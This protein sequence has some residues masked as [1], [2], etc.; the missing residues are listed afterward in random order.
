MINGH[1]F[2][3]HESKNP[4]KCLWRCRQTKSCKARFWIIDGRMHKAN[5]EHNHEQSDFII[6]NGVY[7]KV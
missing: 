5:L 3:K 7:W 6:K 1:I 4:L 2:Y